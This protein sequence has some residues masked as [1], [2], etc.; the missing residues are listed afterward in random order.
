MRISALVLSL[1]A[2]LALRAQSPATLRVLTDAPAP[3]SAVSHVTMPPGWHMT[4]GPA[5][6]L[7]DP[8]NSAAGRFAVE[9]EIFL[10]PGTSQEG[11]GLFVGGS[12]AGAPSAAW[13]AF[14][15]RRDGSALV[16]QRAGGRVSTILAPFP[17]TAVKPHPGEGTSHNVLRVS[18]EPD[19]IRFDA[20][21]QRI[22]AI[23]RGALPL[24]GLFG[25]RVGR[26]L[27]LHVSQLDITRRLAP[28]RPKR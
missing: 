8:A 21:G 6:L 17:T 24:D 28:A 22:A 14:L 4:T 16:E 3:D 23:E 15:V 2:P 19:S 7:Y 13:V 5:A 10:F 27:N 18:V 9:A 20:N 25:F 26:D 12:P 11:Y 1:M